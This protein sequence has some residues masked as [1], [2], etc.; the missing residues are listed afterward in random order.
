[1]RRRALAGLVLA[2]VVTVSPRPA[3]AQDDSNVTL[4]LG[5]IS[6]AVIAAHAQHADPRVIE[7]RWGALLPHEAGALYA[8]TLDGRVLLACCGGSMNQMCVA[9]VT[10]TRMFLA[11]PAPLE[12][13]LTDDWTEPLSLERVF[14]V[15]PAGRGRAPGPW[16]ALL[17]CADQGTSEP[18]VLRALPLEP[19]PRMAA[20]AEVMQ[21]PGGRWLVSVYGPGSSFEILSRRGD[22][23]W[24][25]FETNIERNPDTHVAWKRGA[26][27]PVEVV[28]WRLVRREP[29]RARPVSRRHTTRPA[30]GPPPSP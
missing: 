10:G 6:E 17:C 1:V 12:L 26:A 30:P 2:C 23:R 15:R 14:L 28:D 11:R 25:T 27:V 24:R 7:K 4:A 3:A 19:F 9:F 29:P 21:G 22:V 8:D 20:I 5:R 18:H 16:L 13:G